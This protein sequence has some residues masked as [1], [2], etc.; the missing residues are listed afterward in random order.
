MMFTRWRS[1]GFAAAIVLVAAAHAGASP[2]SAKP[3]QESDSS[4]AAVPKSDQ[5]DSVLQTMDQA[6]SRF[7]SAQADFVWTT[8]NSVANEVVGTDKGK[9]YFRR[10]GK[11]TEMAAEVTSPAPKQIIFTGGK[12]QVYQPTIA[13]VDTYDAGTHREEFETFL[14][15]GFGSSGSDLR[16]SFEIKYLGDEQIGKAKTAKIELVPTSAKVKQQFPRFDL[17]IDRQSGLLVRQQLWQLGGD[18]RLADYS[19]FQLNKKLSDGLFKL[20]TSGSTKIVSH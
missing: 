18:Y 12:I 16:K 14:V 3:Q 5:L 6:A 2:A 17:W 9:I 7:R 1:I 4:P 11:D 13:Q 15:L 8:F 10:S 20:K 19:N